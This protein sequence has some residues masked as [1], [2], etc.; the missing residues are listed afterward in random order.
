M[1]QKEEETPPPLKVL[2]EPMA[3]PQ[4]GSDLEESLEE[5][6]TLTSLTDTDASVM[7]VV[8]MEEVSTNPDGDEDLIKIKVRGV[9]VG[10][11]H[12]FKGGILG[13]CSFHIFTGGLGHGRDC[14]Q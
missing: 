5:E 3:S 6:G 11:E 7:E 1:D 2:D 9:M 12:G 4:K 13:D 8:D 14:R 10:L